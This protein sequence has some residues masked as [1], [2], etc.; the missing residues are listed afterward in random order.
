MP[1]YRGLTTLVMSKF[2]LETFLNTVQTFRATYANLVPPIILQLAR[3]PF[4]NTYDISS[5]RMVM[6]G[7]APLALELIYEPLSE[8]KSTGATSVWPQ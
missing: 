1:A 2:D 6:C 7:A 5:L 4:V 3:I 8:A